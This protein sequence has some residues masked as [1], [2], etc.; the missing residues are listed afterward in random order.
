MRTFKLI[1]EHN[2]PNFNA[3]ADVVL[4]ED[5]LPNGEVKKSLEFAGPFI[6]ADVKNRNG[7]IYPKDLM[8]D[9]ISRYMKD[10][11][12]GPKLRSYGELDHSQD[13]TIN[14]HRISHIVT[15]L[16]W[17]GNDVLGKA[18]IIDTEYGRIAES[19]I[20]ADGQLGV[21]SRG[22][23]SLNQENPSIPHLYESCKRMF[24]EDANIVTEFELVAIDIVA[25]PSAPTAFVNG[26]LESKEYILVGGLYTEASLRKS[27]KAFKNLEESLKRLPKKEVNDYL[28]ASAKRFLA[29]I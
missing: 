22:M 17:K 25:D 7:R 10:R 14:L 28:I 29:D 20:K 3:L 18:K 11:M 19:I 5:K 12:T 23:G 9:T 6:Q 24:G 1:T 16:E 2:Q 13:L 26:I 15:S 27:E 8:V 21:S 4:K